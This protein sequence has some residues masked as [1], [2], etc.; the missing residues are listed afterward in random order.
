MTHCVNLRKGEHMS[1]E[2]NKEVPNKKAQIS[3]DGKTITI[4][5]KNIEPDDLTDFF[6]HEVA[7]LA[8]IELLNFYNK[9]KK[10]SKE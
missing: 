6:L 9:E 5:L 10:S 7:H 1:Q 4:F 8:R 2:K 3:K